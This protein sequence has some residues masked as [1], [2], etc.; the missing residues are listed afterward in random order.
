MRKVTLISFVIKTISL[1]SAYAKSSVLRYQDTVKKLMFTTAS[2]IT[3]NNTS[4]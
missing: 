4:I 3:F 2:S 1:L